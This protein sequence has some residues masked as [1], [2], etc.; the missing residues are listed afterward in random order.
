VGNG[1]AG[2]QQAVQTR[3]QHHWPASDLACRGRSFLLALSTR[4]RACSPF[5]IIAVSFCS[6]LLAMT[7]HIFFALPLGAALFF[8]ALDSR[9]GLWYIVHGCIERINNTAFSERPGP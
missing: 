3:A 4:V 6:C 7:I 1:G 8:P 9:V 2:E 5:V